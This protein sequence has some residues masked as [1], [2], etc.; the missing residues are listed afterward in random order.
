MLPG[1]LKQALSDH[2]RTVK[3]T[4][5]QDRRIAMDRSTSLMLWGG[6]I[7]LPQRN[8]AGS[9]FSPH[10]SFRPTRAQELAAG[11]IYK[12]GIQR[13]FRDAVRKAGI[14]KPDIAA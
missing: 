13:A 11:I 7:P 9:T 12:R 1:S 8:G 2:L 5:E 4:H 6:S 3:K 10:R 14:V